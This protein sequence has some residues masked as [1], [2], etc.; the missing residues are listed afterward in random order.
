[1]L[2][3]CY[4]KTDMKTRDV[5]I[6]AIVGMAGSGKSVAIDYLTDRGVPKSYFGGMNLK[7]MEKRGIEITPE[8]EKIFRK[9]IR[10]EE[11][12]DWVARQVIAEINDLISAGQKRIVL[13]GLYSWTEYRTL[14]KEFPGELTVIAVVCPRKLRYE[15]LS[16]RPV[17]PFDPQS[18][19]ERDYHE[20][21]TI[22]KGGPI[23]IA[24]YFILNDGDIA[25]LESQLK[26]IL[27]EI[28][29]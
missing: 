17:R 2:H 23:A 29:F 24:D 10:D 4:N 25:N 27:D 21:E 26:N 19:R 3:S 7:E 16:A 15:R 8:N 11:G 28:N 1:M 12:A 20:I 18:A 5:K 14:K 13:D 6:L 9:Q 22:E